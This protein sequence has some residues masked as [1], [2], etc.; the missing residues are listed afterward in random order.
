MIEEQYLTNS[1]C[2]VNLVICHRRLQILCISNKGTSVV[3]VEC[4]VEFVIIINRYCVYIYRLVV[5]L[6]ISTLHALI[7]LSWSLKEELTTP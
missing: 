5:V 6:L 4:S 2:L 3:N 1:R 7:Y